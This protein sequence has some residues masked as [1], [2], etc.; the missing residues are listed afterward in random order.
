GIPVPSSDITAA[1][2]DK[3]S[4]EN[5]IGGAFYPGI[6]ASWYVRDHYEFIEPFRLSHTILSAGD[7][8]KQMAVPWQADFYDCSQDDELAWWPAQRP[9]DVYPES[10]GPQ[11]P[12]IRKHVNSASDMVKIGTSS[13][14]SSRKERDT[15]RP[16]V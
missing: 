6:E 16:S 7:V 13:V 1:G 2:L 11:Q 4:L 15:L 14:S 5:C 9:D 12:W 3:A 8:T 10:G